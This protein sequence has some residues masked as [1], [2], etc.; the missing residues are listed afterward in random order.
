M[1]TR[2]LLIHWSEG[3]LGDSSDLRK[4]IVEGRRILSGN[5]FGGF[6]RGHASVNR[7]RP[8]TRHGETMKAYLGVDFRPVKG[9]PILANSGVRRVKEQIR[10]LR[11]NIGGVINQFMLPECDVVRMVWCWRNRFVASVVRNKVISIA[12][13]PEHWSAKLWSGTGGK[14][15]EGHA[16]V[17][18]NCRFHAAPRMPITCFAR[19]RRLNFGGF[20]VKLS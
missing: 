18:W 9:V 4:N 14:E 13:G 16:E 8:A 7:L 2:N 5:P 20:K 1:E 10:I 11:E 15:C 12:T 3:A 6:A 17:N 19:K